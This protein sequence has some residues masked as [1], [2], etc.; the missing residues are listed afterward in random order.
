[1][2]H[3]WLPSHFLAI[4]S[5][6]IGYEYAISGETV[7]ANDAI[8]QLQH[9]ATRTYVP[10]IYMASVY[11]GLHN[12]DHAFERLDKAHDERCE[13]L[14]Y[15]PTEPLADPLRGDPRFRKLLQRL[16]LKTV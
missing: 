4:K 9:L 13:N 12:L 10:A 7:R 2:T 8:S 6:L 3:I 16:R 1:M 15:L 11:T 5:P 14:V